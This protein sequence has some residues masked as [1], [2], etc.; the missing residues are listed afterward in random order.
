MV[1]IFL[2][3][4]IHKTVN[5]L[6]NLQKFQSQSTKIKTDDISEEILN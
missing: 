2:S 1:F 3:I 4:F 6:L 5:E